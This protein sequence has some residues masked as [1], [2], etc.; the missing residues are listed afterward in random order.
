MTKIAKIKQGGFFKKG[1]VLVTNI[2]ANGD[3]GETKVYTT[4]GKVKIEQMDGKYILDFLSISGGS[5]GMTSRGTTSGRI[6]TRRQS[7]IVDSYSF[8]DED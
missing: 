1:R 4:S 2:K 7:I 3:E 5:M 8:I 6:Y